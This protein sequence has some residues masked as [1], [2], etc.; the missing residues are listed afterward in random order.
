MYRSL[1]VPL[2][3]L[4]SSEAALPIAL[5]VTRRTGATLHLEAH[6]CLVRV[7]VRIPLQH[8][9]ARDIAGSP[10]L[11]DWPMLVRE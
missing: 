5:G 10:E 8:R 6:V 1:L 4:M 9:I 3:G 11:Q 2:D 7:A